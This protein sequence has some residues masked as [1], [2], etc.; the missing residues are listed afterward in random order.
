VRIRFS[1]PQQSLKLGMFLTA[2]VPIESHPQALVVP[3]QAVYRDEKNQAVLYRITGD[4]AEAVPVR[5]GLET[6]QQVELLSGVE[7]GDTVILAGGY[8]LGERAKVRVK[9]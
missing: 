6:S 4:T 8:G 3:P 1:N 7:A 2:Q 9:P 5:L